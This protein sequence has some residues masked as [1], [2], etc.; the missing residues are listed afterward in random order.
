MS[1][2]YRHSD[3][4]VN[5]AYRKKQEDVRREQERQR[6]DLERRIWFEKQ[7]AHEHMDDQARK[8]Q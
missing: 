3:K 6:K 7:D 1:R 8:G 4:A 2:S 5:N